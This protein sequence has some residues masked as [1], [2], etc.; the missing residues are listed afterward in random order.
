MYSPE[1]FLLPRKG[2]R[3]VCSKSGTRLAVTLRSEIVNCQSCFMSEGV[4]GL[5]V[6]QS[7]KLPS[8][9]ILS[10]EGWKE[11]IVEGKLEARRCYDL[12][13]A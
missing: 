5:T 3:N 2:R 13:L 6:E 9:A 7:R 11:G 8:A 10:S 1:G 12:E 4:R